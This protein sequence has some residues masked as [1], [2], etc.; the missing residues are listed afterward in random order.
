MARPIV[1]LRYCLFFILAASFAVQASVAAWNL[2]IEQS[3]TLHSQLDS[4]LIFCGAFGLLVLFPVACIDIARKNA[5]FACVWFETLWLALF[6]V[7]ETAGAAALTALLPQ[8]SCT[9]KVPALRDP[10]CQSTNVLTGITWAITVVVLFY[11]TT[12]IICA[13]IHHDT[14]P[15]VW[16]SGVRDF[17]WFEY[18]N[19]AE[20]IVSPPCS[21]A[22]W[23]SRQKEEK[24]LQQ[25]QQQLP[26][27]V[28]AP[29]PTR[30][31]PAPLWTS[32]E[33]EHYTAD[34]FA[35]PR[36]PRAPAP[37]PPAIQQMQARRAAPPSLYPNH[38]ESTVP[39]VLPSSLPTNVR[40]V[41]D[42]PTTSSSPRPSRQQQRTRNSQQTATSSLQRDPESPVVG[43]PSKRPPRGPRNRPSPLDLSQVSA[44][45]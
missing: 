11:M 26:P 10:S 39:P 27:K 28:V 33:V 44:Y 17:A 19:R 35:G 6:F 4:Y 41:G 2:Q 31:A 14:H 38:M 8:L 12:L 20:R 21:P 5:V 22:R 37:P 24:Q 3:L 30:N 18:K 15:D 16:R 40:P 9:Q 25:Q 1:Y 43:P 45:R 42:W 23:C 36:Y 32:Y 13:I 7:L 29:K 34:T